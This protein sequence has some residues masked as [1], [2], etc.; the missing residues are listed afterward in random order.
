MIVQHTG[1]GFGASL[2]SLLDRH[3]RPQVRHVREDTALCPGTVFIGAGMPQHLVL[4]PGN[5]DRVGP[6][7]EAPING[8]RPSVDALFLS[9]VPMAGRCV[10]ALLTGMG[11]DGAKGM[12]ALRDA[13][14]YC[15]AQD[16]RSSVVY[17]MPRA[18]AELG[19]ADRILPLDQI[20]PALLQA[21]RREGG[22]R[23]HAR[24]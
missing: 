2:A 18:A 10:V 7:A 9:A 1:E 17:G 20:G 22:L 6:R 24:T 4:R 3:S 14:A 12:K 5:P 21:A 23:P 13:G 8:H 15:I 16:E 19:A 11:T